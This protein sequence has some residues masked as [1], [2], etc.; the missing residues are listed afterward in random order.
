MST[1][2]QNKAGPLAAPSSRTIETNP[3]GGC[4]SRMTGFASRE[5]AEKRLAERTAAGRGAHSYILAPGEFVPPQPQPTPRMVAG[6][7]SRD[8]NTARRIREV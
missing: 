8:G 6:T 4:R 1:W 5:E 3:P 7:Y 2:H